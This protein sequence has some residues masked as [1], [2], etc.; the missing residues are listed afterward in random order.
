VNDATERLGRRLALGWTLAY[1]GLI[2]LVSLVPAHWRLE[3]EHV[4]GRWRMLRETAHFAP[5][6]LHGLRDLATNFL[7]YVPLGLL[8]PW[9]IKPGRRWLVVAGVFLGAVLSV[10]L[11]IAQVYTS[12]Y[13]S[14][15]DVAMN[16]CG[17]AAAYLVVVSA[18]SRRGLSAALFAGRRAATSRQRLASGLTFIYAPLLW[19]LSLLPLNVNV[20][21]EMVWAKLHGTLAQGG[22]VLLDV[23]T[24]WDRGRVMGVL[25]GLLL[26]V[27]FGF[28]SFVAHSDRGKR[29]Y[30]PAVLYGMLLAAAI[31]AGQLLVPARSSDVLQVLA[32]GV[33]AALG[34][35]LARAWDR[36]SVASE[37]P[38][39]KAFEWRDGLLFGLLL[40]TL[41]LLAEAWRPY[42]FVST[43]RDLLAR[44]HQEVEW[45]PLQTYMSG[46]RSLV[47]FKDV[48]SEAA[49]YVPLGMMLQAY[50]SRVRLP[51]W[52]PRPLVVALLVVGA[53]GT[54]FELGQVMVIGRMPG[55][56]DVLSHTVGGLAGYLLLSA[57]RRDAEPH[58]HAHR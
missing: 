13:P 51:A 20:G 43:P 46:P 2:V 8:L 28:L 22:R 47:M 3:P 53:L 45:I 35:L 40:Y 24:P 12:R 18:I 31:E 48:G 55:A 27:P 50:L 32:G 10:G 34:V 52:A 49:L 6:S 23:A 21:S 33:G 7:L 5:R 25:V 14:A 26:L 30:M 16:A 11:E 57:L 56:T 58:A 54:F 42:T 17:H 29:A 19:L 4:A 44:L 41:V 39:V 1:V 37:A 9:T 38:G 15:W 36:S